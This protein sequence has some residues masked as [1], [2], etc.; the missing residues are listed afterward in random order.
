MITSYRHTVSLSDLL[1]CI[2]YYISKI[3]LSH[4][5]LIY[6]FLVTFFS[7]TVVHEIPIIHALIFYTRIFL[8]YTFCISLCI[9]ILLYKNSCIYL[10]K[11]ILF[12]CCF[13]LSAAFSLFLNKSSSSF[14][15]A[16][17]EYHLTLIGFVYSLV[18]IQTLRFNYIKTIGALF[19]LTA[20]VN[21]FI[22][23]VLL[24]L[25][26]DERTTAHISAFFSDRNMFTRFL[27]VTNTFLL[28]RFFSQKTKK[29]LSLTFLSIFLIFICV[30]FMYS[31]GGYI[32]YFLSVGY[33]I[34]L[35]KNNTI[36]KFGVLF[37]IL[38]TILFAAMIYQRVQKD[39]MTVKNSSD[40]ARVSALRAGFN[41]IKHKPLSGVGYAMSRFKYT[42]YEDKS[43]PGLTGMHTIH[44]V[45]VNI[46][47]EQGIVGLSFYLLFNFGLLYALFKEMADHKNIKEIQNE[48]FCFI[49]L[50]TYLLH[51][52]VYHTFDSDAIYWI[53]IAL[54]IITLKE[55][56]PQRGHPI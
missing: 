45:Y 2:L 28:I 36:R 37:G 4:Y 38:M 29:I 20:M 34:W 51:G 11:H 27:V 24:K 6:A 56:K 55:S 50:A 26:W 44:N 17:Y 33:I 31:R 15:D 41:M 53:I 22:S 1:G 47:A 54:S 40:L 12:M 49:S 7:S 19:I 9:N 48:L 39:L 3:S 42:E 23:F 18:V 13:I 10:D 43:L 30:T 8:L 52:L 32:L 16:L 35:T 14:P 25:H 21:I 46:F 5:I